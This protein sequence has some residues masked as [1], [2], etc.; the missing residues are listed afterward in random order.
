MI[1]Y[2]ENGSH[3]RPVLSLIFILLIRKRGLFLSFIYEVKML[4]N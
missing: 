2:L 1:V 4:A 3:C